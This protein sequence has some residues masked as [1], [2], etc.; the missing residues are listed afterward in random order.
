M[1]GSY[2]SWQ[3]RMMQNLKRNWL[4]SS[5]L[6]WGIWRILTRA[7]ENLI[8]LHFNGLSFNKVYNVWAKKSIGEICLMALNIHATFEGKLTCA[9]KNDR[10]N[11]TNF[12]QSKFESLKI[13][14][15]MGSFYQKQK[16]YELKI[17]SED[18][19]QDIEE[20]YK[21]WRV[22]DLSV[23]NWHEEFDEFWP[24]TQKSQK[25]AL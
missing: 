22:I 8:N 19:C 13:G 16:M 10:R 25:F 2:V 21:I 4:L 17:Y 3:W 6:T 12:H 18:L 9:F 14:T 5:K 23:Q 7:L 24:S 11:L 15:L 20:W 1:Q